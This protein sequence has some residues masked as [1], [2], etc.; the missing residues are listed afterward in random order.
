MEKTFVSFRQA[1]RTLALA[2]IFG[3]GSAALYAQTAASPAVNLDTPAAATPA[4]SSSVQ[5]NE[6]ALNTPPAALSGLNAMQ[7]GGRRSG[8]PRYRG[9]NTN[10]DGSEKYSF[11]FGVG[12]TAPTQDTDTYNTPSWA[13]GLGVARNFNR[14]AG[15]QVEFNYD[16]FGLKGSTLANQTN[17]YNYFTNQCIADPVCSASVAAQG[18]T[19]SDF[20]PHD[21]DGNMHDWSFALNPM[22]TF[23][24]GEGMGAYVIGGVG[25]F[26][27]VTNFTTPTVG[28]Y[29]DP[30]YGPEEYEA[31]QVIDHYTSNAPGLDGGLGLTYKFS[32]FSNERFYV[33]ARYV[34][35]FNQY[36]PG[37]TSANAATTSYNGYNEYPANSLR[38]SY[39]PIKVGMRF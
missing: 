26:H 31:N 5:Q 25:F 30:Y 10:A 27:K 38:T 12:M 18:G 20:G 4:F 6:I 35:T 39:F 2:A 17:L 36:R 19:L 28:V 37:F 23:Y 29:Y 24:S 3:A 14:H 22:Y 13:F 32:R 1:G 16:N 8:R 15:V 34:Y 7:Y 21:L 33:E 9:G 11:F